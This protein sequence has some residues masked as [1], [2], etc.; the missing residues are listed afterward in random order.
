MC[1]LVCVCCLV[2]ANLSGVSGVVLVSLGRARVSALVGE[3]TGRE[4][5]RQLRLH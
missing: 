1:G 2:F 4:Q 5:T 3:R